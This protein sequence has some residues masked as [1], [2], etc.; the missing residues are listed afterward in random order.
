VVLLVVIELCTLAFRRDRGSKADVIATALFGDGAA[1]A[2]LCTEGGA[3]APL[4]LGA[5]SEHTWPDT[6]GIMGWS[7]PS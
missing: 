4:R 2:I 1:A 5:A 3:N 7:F 6:L